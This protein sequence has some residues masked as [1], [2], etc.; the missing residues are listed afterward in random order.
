MKTESATPRIYLDIETWSG[1]PPP[2]DNFKPAAK[3]T[4][5]IEKTEADLEKVEVDILKVAED[6]K[7]ATEDLSNVKASSRLVDPVKIEEDV[8]K[9][10]TT[11]NTKIEALIKKHETLVEK[12]EALMGKIVKLGMSSLADVLAKQDEAWRKQSLDPHKGEVFCIGVAVNDE[13]PFCIVGADEEETMRQLETELEGYGMFPKIYGHN[14]IEF[15]GYWLFLKGLKYGLPA[16][17]GMF[18]QKRNLIDTMALLDGPAWK[19]MV[20]Q[21]KMADI[22]GVQGKGWITGGM[23]HDLIVHGMGD[24]VCEYVCSDVTTLRECAK[25]LSKY[26]LR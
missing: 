23:V 15:D 19:K 26:G 5:D 10:K 6:M 25:K 22:L 18:S 9:K 13:E 17:V 8:A 1:E 12:Q 7:K 16:T 20:S 2:L 24:T 21:D 14:I 11:L 4:T 3:I